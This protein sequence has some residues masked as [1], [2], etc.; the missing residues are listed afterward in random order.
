MVQTKENKKA[1]LIGGGTYGQVYAQYLKEDQGYQIL[2]YYDDQDKKINYEWFGAL[3]LLDQAPK[4]ESGVTIDYFC[5]I[6]NNKVRQEVLTRLLSLGHSTP[7]YI[8]SS[9]SIGET[10]NIGRAVYILPGCN[11]MPFVEVGDYC[12][13][14]M[15]VN[16]SHHTV[17]KSASFLAAGT[18]IGA[19]LTIESRCFVGTSATIM[20]GVKS[21]GPDAT[22]GAGSVVIRNVEAMQTVI[23]VPAKV[24]RKD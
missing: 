4:A 18:N 5:P 9:V 10:V 24:L 1:I 15:G 22:V 17:L 8:H 6:G 16:I 7:S 21:V 19:S 12:M 3:A 23:G 20:T 2:G 14:S 11:L 13:M